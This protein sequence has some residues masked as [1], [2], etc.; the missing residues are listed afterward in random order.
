VPLRELFAALSGVRWRQAAL[1][2]SAAGLAGWMVYL[3]VR[4]GDPL[5]FLS[6]QQAP[7]WDQGSGP[8]TWFKVGFVGTLVFQRWGT[9]AL[10][11]P[12]ALACLAAVL[13]LRT[14]W[15]RFGWGYTAYAFVSLAIPIIGTKDFMGAG[16][17]AL[18]AYP[19]MAAAAVVLAEG[20][21]PRWLL[22]VVLVLLSIG[23]CVA[24]VAFVHGVEVS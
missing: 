12:Q 2:L 21:R 3:A 13:L 22:P 1:L 7:G 5:A 23:L 20:R 11:I 9:A 15:R 17:Y 14:T 6:V 8:H 4:F 19:V 18:A 10:L 16:R 24:T